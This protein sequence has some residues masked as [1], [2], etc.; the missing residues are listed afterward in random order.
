[1]TKELS[2]LSVPS[3]MVTRMGNGVLSRLTGALRSGA[4]QGLDLAR[5]IGVHTAQTIRALSSLGAMRGV[6]VEAT[7]LA[8]HAVLYPLGTVAQDLRPDGPYGHY[9]TDDLPPQQR[10]LVV[11]AM[12]AAGTPIVLIHG[13]ADN[14]SAFALLGGALRRRGFGVVHALNYGW[15]TALTGDIRRAA[16]LLGTHIERI[17]EQTGS[18]RVH[19]VGHSLGGLVARYYVQRLGGDA[20]V[21]TLVTLG[22]PHQGTLAAYLLPTRLAGQLRPGSPLLTELAGP[23]PGCR[24][25]FVVVWSEMDQVVIPQRNARLVHPDL[26][27]EEHRLPDTGHLSLAVDARA[28]HVVVTT[29][30]RLEDDE[31]PTG[32][33]PHP[34]QPGEPPAHRPSARVHHPH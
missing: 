21:R 11:A 2:T 6:V 1:M 3:P 25:R 34:R 8:L 32:L 29:L 16:E 20:R 22:T 17:C 5:D 28:R 31:S 26:V 15:L 9:R 4:G 10:G 18:E 12:E 24:T 33:L 19:I 27:I 14:R 23:A 7:W 13:V 30:A